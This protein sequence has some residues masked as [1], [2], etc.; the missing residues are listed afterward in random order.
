MTDALKQEYT[1]R[2]TQANRSELTVIIY[3]MI[4]DYIK[5]AKNAGSEIQRDEFREAIRKAKGCVN[6]LIKT[7]DFS[8]DI[9]NG[10]LK[11]YLFANKQLALADISKRTDE[12]NIIERI[13]HGLHSSFSKISQQDNSEPLMRNTQ[14]IY[15]GL[16]Y[17][18]NELNETLGEQEKSR[19]FLA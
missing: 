18:K 7:L 12:L 14:N 4:L 5:D 8:Y 10:L 2:I 11:L 17:G 1:L 16:T 19:G 6:E 9:S 15:A 3:E 13:M